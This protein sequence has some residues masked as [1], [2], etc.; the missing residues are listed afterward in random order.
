MWGYFLNNGATNHAGV[1]ACVVM[2]IVQKWYTSLMIVLYSTRLALLL[3]GYI[4]EPNCLLYT[5]FQVGVSGANPGFSEGGVR[6]RG[7]YRREE[8]A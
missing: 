6:I 5:K 7:G 2:L 8:L 1:Y 3:K 4:Q